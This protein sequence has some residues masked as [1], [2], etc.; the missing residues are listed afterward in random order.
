MAIVPKPY[1]FSANTAIR[2]SE[3]N[4]DIDTIY[5][6]FNGNISGTNVA[7]SAVTTLKLAD[8]TITTDNIADGAITTAKIIDDA[9]TGAQIDWASTGA[10]GGIWWEELGRAT[11]SGN[12]DTITVSNIEP[13]RYLRILYFP[14]QTG[15]V[16][17]N[18]TFNNDSGANYSSRET[19]NGA[20]DIT[21]VSQTS[22]LIIGVATARPPYSVIDVLNIATQEKLF[23]EQ[24]VE[25]TSAG[26]G[27][28]ASRK[29]A[30]GKWAN[31]TGSIHTVKITNASTG[32]FIA[33][34]ELIVL[35]H[36]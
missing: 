33:S 15:S 31:T 29:E 19:T 4:A 21:S 2:P 8:T 9:V 22:F 18:L 35:G 26:A 14:Y 17:G 24:R 11:L 1:T 36:N 27:T 6:A 16:T 23:I 34:S 3:V 13:R 28:A 32:D 7:S 20:A 25:L 12:A 10:D 5:N 30:I